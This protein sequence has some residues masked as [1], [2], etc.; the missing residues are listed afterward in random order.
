MSLKDGSQK[1]SKS[2]L[3]EY[4]RKSLDESDEIIKKIKKQKLQI[5]LCQEKLRKYKN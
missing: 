1:M 5:Q 3:S 4:S 2:D